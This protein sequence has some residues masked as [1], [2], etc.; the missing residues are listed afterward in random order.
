MAATRYLYLA[1]HG[2]AVADQSGL[3]GK[4]RRQAEL[5]GKRLRD[6][7]FSGFHH[8]PLARAVETAGVVGGQLRAGV[9]PEVSQAAGDYLP[10][11]PAAGEVPAEYADFVRNVLAQFTPDE[12]Q[13]GP[14][15]AR[16]ALD[17]FTGPADG[18]EDQHELLITHNFLVG[19]L[20]TQAL[21][22]PGWRWLTLNHCNAA[23]TVLRYSPGRPATALIYNDMRHLPATHR[24]TG[25]PKP[26][27]GI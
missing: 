1:R 19:Y 3:T 21:G 2:E 11:A 24:W 18:P 5:L 6:V 10:A 26:E 20:V 15:L 7:P 22:A 4:G 8:S 25:F 12:L 9:P 14:P 13:D 16:Q 27:P 23:L 17:L